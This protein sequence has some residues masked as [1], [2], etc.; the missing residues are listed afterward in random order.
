MRKKIFFI[1]ALFMATIA[2]NAQ[3]NF[4]GYEVKAENAYTY[5]N[6]RW[7]TGPEDAK[8]YTTDRLRKE[9]LIEKVFAPG[10]VNWTYTM[11]DR[12]LIGGAEPTATPLKLTSIA[13]LYVDES[14]G[15][16]GRNL[17][18][19]RELGIINI[20]GE[21]TVTVDGKTYSLGFQDALYVGRGAKEI[22]VASKNAA[23]PAKLKQRPRYP[24]DDYRRCGRCAHM[25]ATDGNHRIEAGIGLEHYACPHTPAPY[26]GIYVLQGS[27][28]PE[29]SA[30]HGRA[31][32]DTAY[33]D[34]QRTGCHLSAMVNPL[35]SRNKQLYLH[36]GYGGRE[37]RIHRHAGGTNTRTEIN[38]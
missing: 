7:A 36:L 17:L 4:K 21:G 5:Y 38:T 20:G 12:F 26:G 35:C 29:N 3:C 6:V 27:E 9:Y 30:R 13:P 11:Y 37:S 34:E 1:A 18:D 10:E 24:S 8:H 22:T 31:T 15:T 16:S 32:R 28:R 19:N 2:G 25:P 33:M 14:K 23:E